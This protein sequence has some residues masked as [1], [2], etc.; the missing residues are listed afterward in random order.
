MISY[1]ILGNWWRHFDQKQVVLLWICCVVTFVKPP[2]SLQISANITLNLKTTLLL[3]INWIRLV[4]K[5]N[6]IIKFKGVLTLK[7]ETE[8]GSWPNLQSNF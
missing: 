8:Y 7:S 4:F 3:K 1:D 5:I 6:D 2:T